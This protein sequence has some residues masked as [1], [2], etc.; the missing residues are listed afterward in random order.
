VVQVSINGDPL[1]RPV[2]FTDQAPTGTAGEL[3]SLG[4]KMYMNN[5][6]SLFACGRLLGTVDI[7]T[8]DRHTLR[9]QSIS[10]GQNTNNVDLIQFIPVDMNQLSPKF[11]QSGLMVP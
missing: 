2:T 1:P 5:V 10:G 9:M 7:K 11:T 3:E 8:T 4:W 6:T